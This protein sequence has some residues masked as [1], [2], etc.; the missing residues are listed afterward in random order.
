MCVSSFLQLGFQAFS[1]DWHSAVKEL[2]WLLVSVCVW[3]QFLQLDFQAFSADWLLHSL[4]SGHCCHLGP[5]EQSM[6]RFTSSFTVTL[7]SEWSPFLDSSRESLRRYWCVWVSWDWVLMSFVV[8]HT[9]I[10]CR[11]AHSWLGSSGPTVRLKLESWLYW[12]R[13]FLLG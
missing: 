4:S 7:W 13:R 1:A 5:R 9:D 12:I 3:T 10:S 11:N 6:Q 8:T 2:R